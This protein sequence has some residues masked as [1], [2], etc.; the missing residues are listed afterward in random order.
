[1]SARRVLMVIPRRLQPTLMHLLPPVDA[2]ERMS[3]REGEPCDAG[4][5]DIVIFIADEPE[6]AALVRSLRALRKAQPA[7]AI[8]VAEHQLSS[9]GILQLLDAGA[10]DFVALPVRNPELS[11]RISMLCGQG[12][13][14]TSTVDLSSIGCIGRSESFTRQVSM[15]PRFAAS[16]AGVLITGE[17]GTGKEVCA[18]AIHYLSPRASKPWVAV[19]CGAVP[20][21]LIESELFGHVKGSF[22]NAHVARDGLVREAEGG[23]LF[24]DDIDCLPQLAQAKLLR[25]LQEREYRP[26]GSNRVQRANVRVIAASN[27]HLPQLVDR[28]QFRQD[29]FFR[30]NVLSIGLPPLRERRQDIPELAMHFL[31]KLRQKGTSKLQC[32][33]PAALRKL[34]SYEWPGNVRELKHVLERASVLC[35]GETL[36]KDDIELPSAGCALETSFK[37]SKAKVVAAFERDYIEA[38]LA[39]HTGNVS[40]AARSAGKDRRAFFELMRKHSIEPGQF[41]S[42]DA[43]RRSQLQHEPAVP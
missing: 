8:L 6:V 9:A 22:T 27:R 23:T 26:V 19:N 20:V 28:G 24:L 2:W 33:T 43:S 25:F 30:L 13:V 37:L 5:D 35:D 41:R 7:A 3:V 32:I 21:E 11:A 4:A 14:Q 15:L 40:H 10:D 16:E 39:V 18:Q 42:A 34:L 31:G 38:M 1:M 17:T 12:T 29:L 36:T